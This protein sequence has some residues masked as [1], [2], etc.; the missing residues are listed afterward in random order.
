MRF[1]PARLAELDGA[2]KI[3]KA[4]GSDAPAAQTDPGVA[5][6]VSGMLADIERGGIDAV[7]RY[8]RELDGWDRP[9]VEVS[10]DDLKRAG[11]DLSPELRRALELG[12]ERTSAFAREQRARLTDFE[13][14]LAPAWSP[15][16]GTSR[17]SGSAPTCRP[18]ASRCWRARA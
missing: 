11:D 4:P 12:V 8:A 7:L 3:L 10:R 17:S 14:E 15:G 13:V 5:E 6:R 9:D 1:T 2:Y 18:A 16:S